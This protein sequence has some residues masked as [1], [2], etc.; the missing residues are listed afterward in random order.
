MTGPGFDP[1]GRARVRSLDNDRLTNLLHC[2]LAVEHWPLIS[3]RIGCH[4][5]WASSPGS[6]T[7]GDANAQAW[8][9]TG[10]A[11]AHAGIDP[12]RGLARLVGGSIRC[13]GDPGEHPGR[14][15]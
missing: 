10:S 8:G 3:I 1:V 7:R 6:G 4:T 12:G 9:P 14:V 13:P 2:G 15:G 11:R 5:P